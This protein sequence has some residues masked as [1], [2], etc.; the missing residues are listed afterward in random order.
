MR[1]DF[2][3]RLQVQLRDAA[4]RE[5]RRGAVGGGLRDALRS[6][7]LAG[8]VASVALALVVGAGALMLR[9]DTPPAGPAVVAELQLTDNPEQLFNAFGSVWIADPVDGTVVRVDPERRAVLARVPVGSAQHLPLAAVGGELWAI[10]T[11]ETQLL[12]IDPSANRVT[13]RVPLDRPDGRPFQALDLLATERSVWAISA[14]GMLQLDPQTGAGRRLVAQPVRDTEARWMALGD[15]T[16]W[17]Y[18]T[19][20]AIRRF[21]AVSGASLGR[22]RPQ[23]PGTMFLGDHGDDLI[24]TTDDGRIGRLDG[25]SGAVRWQRALADRINGGTYGA[26]LLWVSASKAR[27]SDRLV[28]LDPRDGAVVVSAPIKGYGASGMAVV[29]DEVWINQAGGHTLVVAR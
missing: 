18:G 21:D 19:D 28:G 24:A 3:T 29:G 4:E 8:A 1:E 17:V 15:E 12:R 7:A 23:L 10:G 20:G 14:E 27:E 2:V 25:E 13:G 6:P 11:D 16:L 9:D 22:L 5:A 26:G